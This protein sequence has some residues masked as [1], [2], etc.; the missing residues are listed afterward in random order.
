M[1][2]LKLTALRASTSDVERLRGQVREEKIIGA[3][4]DQQRDHFLTKLLLVNGLIPSLY[5]FFRDLQYL[6]ACVDCVKRLISLSPK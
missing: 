6:Q 3:F 2:T 4:N 5:T 1:I